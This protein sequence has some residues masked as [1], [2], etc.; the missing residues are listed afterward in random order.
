[1]PMFK[2]MLLIRAYCNVV[3]KITLSG[4]PL[5][6][7]DSLNYVSLQYDSRY[8]IIRGVLQ[9]EVQLAA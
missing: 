7:F 1:M 6:V 8:R 3:T 4:K 2:L 9:T 5:L